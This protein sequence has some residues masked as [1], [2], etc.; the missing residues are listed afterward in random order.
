M[1]N[2]KRFWHKI[3]GNLGHYKEI[4]I[5]VIGIEEGEDS[6]LEGPETVFNKNHRR[7]FPHPKEMTMNV[8]ENYRIPNGLD[9]KSKPSCHIIIKALNVQNKERILKAAMGK[10]Q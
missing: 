3:K 4:K 6:Q 2:L 1:L 8:Q 10:G 5:T 7:K 9:Q